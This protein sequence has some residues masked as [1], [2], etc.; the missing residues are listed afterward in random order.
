MKSYPLITPQQNIWNL[1][2]YYPETSIANVSGMLR[3]SSV[4]NYEA[5]AQLAILKTGGAYMPIDPNYP[6][7][8]IDFMLEDAKC[9]VTLTLGIKLDGIDMG[10]DSIFHDNTSAP[11]NIN[12]SEDLC[13][14][15]YTSGSTG[16]PKGA[17]LIHRGIVNYTF[18]NDALYY[19][20]NCVICFSIS[21][22]DAFTL[23]T[24]LP[25]IRGKKS[26]L[27]DE[28][29]L[30]SQ[31]GFEDL[32]SMNEK[33]NIFITPA[34][35]K[36]YVSNIS[37]EALLKNINKLCIGGEVF[38]LEILAQLPESIE[39]FNVYGPTECS[40]WTSEYSVPR[41]ISSSVPIGRSLANTQIYILDKNLQP[42][43]IGAVG[44][45]CI[46]GDGVGRGYLN[47]PELTAEKFVLNPFISGKR[48]YKTGDL[49][50]W[51]EDGQLEYIGRMDNQV[52]IRG[53]RIELGEIETA[54][55]NSADVRQIAVVDKKD[56]T[57]RQ[58]IC[59]Y[60]ISENEL[61]EKMLR[62]E[63]AKTL[64]RYMIPHYFIRLEVFPTTSS[65]KT[66]R[67]SLPLPDFHQSQSNSD[68][69]APETEQEKALI[70]LLES[71]LD[72]SPIGMSDDFFDIGGDSL[73]AI[74]FIS[75]A[76]DEGFQISVQSI[77]E[78]PTPAE[79]LIHI[80]AEYKKT[81]LYQAEDFDSIHE[82]L[83]LNR[84]NTEA[85]SLTHPI[86]DVLITGAT[87]WLGS[88][89]L[90]EFLS[91]ETGIAY[92]LVRGKD[93]TDSQNKL[94]VV[95][96]H[97]FGDKYLN[98]NRIVVVC[99]DIKNRIKFDKPINTIIHSAANVKHYGAYSNSY[100]VNVT[101]TINIINLAK[102]KNAKLLHI[103]TASVSG[104][105]FDND[106]DFPITVFDETNLYIGQPLEN[107]YVRSK[108][109]AEVAVLKA[110]REGLD[111]AVI[112]IGNLSNRH[113][114]MMFQMNHKENATLTRLK[115]FIE[116]GLYPELLD[117]FELEFSPVCDSAKAIITIAKNNNPEHSVYHSY[118]PVAISFNDFVNAL[119]KMNIK[120]H[121]VSTEQFIKAINDNPQIREVFIQDVSEK[122]TLSYKSSITLNNE[123]TTTAL[124]NH[125]FVWS[126]ICENYLTRYIKYFKDIGHIKYN[127]I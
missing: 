74:E 20:G 38:P 48:M 123:F 31:A 18:S 63:L 93:I 12:M 64:P 57:G 96:E 97:Y 61:D 26:V 3:F 14:L 16:I 117:G 45:L 42:M 120:I 69:V 36:N 29:E 52:K 58:Y 49:A 115:A 103:S 9:K 90:D 40:M 80:S 85:I 84:T 106:S 111:A 113:A 114:D 8:R 121:P 78:H 28:D 101:G 24:I 122:G 126:K 35:L 124:N 11:D 43:P 107:I 53:L 17:M 33:C 125:G 75:K 116:L 22:F 10:D 15:I 44:E 82:M 59:A 34:K 37:N 7:E 39:I 76:Q 109:E 1:Q 79:L 23:E 95:L 71:V 32:L 54:I 67:K 2:K 99:G 6:K 98:N 77:F 110:K 65:G 86:G 5:L 46:S 30:F 62:T 81:A 102:E 112:R 105:A 50:R 41:D 47:R 70:Q 19:G 27:S 108:F 66:D 83:K 56:E 60:Y 118:N 73:K 104:N 88:H 100:D 51:R 68:Y 119:V 55:T 91:S 13:A 94:K 92:C 127:T 25:L 72:I 4:Y 89:V 87:G 21:T